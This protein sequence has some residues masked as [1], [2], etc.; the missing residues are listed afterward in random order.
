M[1]TFDL[2]NVGSPESISFLFHISMWWKILY[3]SIRIIIGVILLNL[4]GTPFIDIFSSLMS[5]EVATDPNDPLYQ[6]VY[7]ILENHSFTVTYFVSIYLLFWGVI[8]IVFSVLLL[9]HKLW[10]FPFSIVMM[11][12]FTTYEIYRVIHTKSLILLSLILLS[13][14]IMYLIY[15]EYRILEKK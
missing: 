14:G 5:H 2:E 9:R 11:G 12:M 6:F 1:E 8:D 4:I 13:L 7:N 15:N 10:A 3:G